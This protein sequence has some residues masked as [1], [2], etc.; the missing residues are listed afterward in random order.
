MTE[1]LADSNSLSRLIA[2][3]IVGHPQQRITFAEF[4]DLA[5]YHPQ[6]GY[7]ATKA[8]TIGSKGDFFTSPHLAPDFGELLAEQFAQMWEIMQRPNPFSLV[9]VGAGQGVLAADI[10]RHLHRH[11]PECYR[12]LDYQIV[13]RAAPLIAEQQ[14]QLRN[15]EATGIRLRWQTL[16]DIPAGSI[17]GCVFS[18][19]LVDALPVHLVAID[20][21]QLREVYVTATESES[22]TP[23][24]GEVL[25]ELSMPQLAE[26]FSAVGVDLPSPRYPD[27]YRTEVNLAALDW[28]SA[29]AKRLQRGYV[30]TIDYGYA[31]DRYYNPAR[32]QGTLQCYYRH[33]HHSDPYLYIGDQDITAHVDFTA[34]QRQ[35]ERYGLQT[36]GFIQQALFLMALGLGDRIAAVGQS[37]ATDVQEVQAR[38]RRRDALHQLANPLGL[39]NFG[40][41]IQSKGLVENA[42][43]L[44]GLMLPM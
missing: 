17:T 38:L 44:K 11:Y 23:Q 35:G 34:L 4:M 33:S 6:Y 28:I 27:G 21:G 19:E 10:L 32:S 42:A 9:E 18:N 15:L 43:Q 41:L 12:C 14:R 13:E 5:L 7:Y 22:R 20:T 31:S 40:V 29:V 30:V 2:R 26:Y 37:D 24:F 8:R 16:E 39:G 36:V 25:D 1:S 3:Q